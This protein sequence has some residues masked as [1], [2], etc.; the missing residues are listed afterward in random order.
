[1]N[2]KRLK[3]IKAHMS[4]RMMISAAMGCEMDGSVSEALELLNYIE[5]LHTKIKRLKDEN[6][7]LKNKGR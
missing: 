7:E 4:K 6:K 3:D 5:L 2:D 1:M